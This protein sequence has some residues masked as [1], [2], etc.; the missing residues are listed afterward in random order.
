ME[1][2]LVQ[3]SQ[4]GDTEAFAALVEE[5]RNAMYHLAWRMVGSSE[6]AADIVQDAF[7]RAYRSIGRFEG[8]S[9]FR[10]WIHRITVH[11]CLNHLRSR[12]R[13]GEVAYQE[14]WMDG[15]GQQGIAGSDR[16]VQGRVE[17]PDQAADRRDL[18]LA[19]EHAL[20]QL[21]PDHRAAFLLREYNGLSYKEIAE[22]TGV[23]IGTVMSRLHYARKALQG[24]LQESLPAHTLGMERE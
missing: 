16:R 18:T 15:I 14:E 7:V 19:I 22:A 11:C 6:D 4:A 2:D 5:H 17:R 8:R 1:E 13:K 21:S 3:R 23:S 10:T 24:I 20:E 9:S 12:K